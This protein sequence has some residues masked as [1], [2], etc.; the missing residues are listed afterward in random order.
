MT[1]DGCIGLMAVKTVIRKGVERC[2]ALLVGFHCGVRQLAGANPLTISRTI[3]SRVTKISSEPDPSDRPGRASHVV[4][5]PPV[6]AHQLPANAVVDRDD[7]G[8]RRGYRRVQRI[9]RSV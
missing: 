9:W 6:A 7:L 5:E 3:I 2:S 1:D 8:V 4:F